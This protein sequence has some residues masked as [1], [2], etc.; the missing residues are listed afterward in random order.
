MSRSQELAVD[1]PVAIISHIGS[2]K[3]ITTYLYLSVVTG[4]LSPCGSNLTV[5]QILF[6]CRRAALL[7]P[8]AR[9]SGNPTTW[10]RRNISVFFGGRLSRCTHSDPLELIRTKDLQGFHCISITLAFA[11]Q[12]SLPSIHIREPALKTS[13]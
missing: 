8:H 10:Q 2:C 11:V 3:I 6:A 13:T 1:K 5:S 7:E 4:S 9:A 12:K